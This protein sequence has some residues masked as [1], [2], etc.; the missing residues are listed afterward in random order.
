MPVKSDKIL[1]SCN[2]WYA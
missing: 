1:V 2:L